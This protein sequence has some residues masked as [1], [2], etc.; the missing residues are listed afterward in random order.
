MVVE[1]YKAP[2]LLVFFNGYR[3]NKASSQSE[4]FLVSAGFWKNILKLQLLSAKHLFYSFAEKHDRF[5][6]KML[7]DGLI[8]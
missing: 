7:H 5:Y 8:E 4:L 1:G 3:K 2:I 6:I